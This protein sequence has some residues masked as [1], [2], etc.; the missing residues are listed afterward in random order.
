MA[1]VGNLRDLSFTDLVQTC[2]TARSTAHISLDFGD[3]TGS[4]FLKNGEIIAAEIGNLKGEKAF[5]K[6]LL[7]Q[8]GKFSTESNPE[9]LP[10]PTITRSW[11]HLLLDGM[12]LLDEIVMGVTNPD[13]LEPSFLEDETASANETFVFN[14]LDKSFDSGSNRYLID[15]HNAQIKNYFS[16]E[17]KGLLELAVQNS[18]DEHDA[19]LQN[20]LSSG[21]VKGGVVVDEDGS[22]ICEIN[23][24]D[25][26]I[27]RLA[28]LVKGIEDVVMSAFN[29]G[30]L[31]GAVLEVQQKSLL[32]KNFQNLS[33]VF[34]RPELVPIVRAFDGVQKAF[35]GAL[36]LPR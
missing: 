24:N 31:N 20:L 32:I 14:A 6:I 29:L 2:C 16:S 30:E 35:E 28:F 13:L 11:R 3:D 9:F 15:E 18:S 21:V 12:Y 5:Y 17:D 27:S 10:E 7:Q 23:E 26:K 8:S 4:V 1:L 22:T 33:L 34:A 25:P 36:G 19:L